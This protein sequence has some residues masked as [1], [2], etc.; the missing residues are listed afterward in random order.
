M[1]KVRNFIAIAL[2]ALL[3]G[4]AK[5]VPKEKQAYV[6]EW[7]GTAM[8]LL[9]T[10][11][12]SVAYRRLEGGVTKSIDGPLKGFDGDNF[13]VGVGPIATTFIVSAPPRQEGGVWKMTVDGVVLTRKMAA[14]ET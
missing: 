13:V 2:I 14:R 1:R 7:N 11:D 3:V 5:P 12:G 8:A 6:G 9:I 10:Q 4:C